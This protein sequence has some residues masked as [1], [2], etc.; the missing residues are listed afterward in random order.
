MQTATLTSSNLM[1]GDM[2]G[3]QIIIMWVADAE[4]FANDANKMLWVDKRWQY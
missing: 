1:R 2:S 3:F 4:R